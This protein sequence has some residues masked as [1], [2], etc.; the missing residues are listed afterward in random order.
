MSAYADFLAAKARRHHAPGIDVDPADD[1]RHIC[2]LQLGLIERVIHLWSNPGETVLTPFMGIG[3]EVYSAVKL[4]RVGV[5][6]E[7][8]PSYWQT[9]V[10]NL[11]ALDDEMSVPTLFDVPA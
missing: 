9:A 10:A 4:G 3:S 7:L 1:E 6:C 2:P 5:G 8:K 11:R